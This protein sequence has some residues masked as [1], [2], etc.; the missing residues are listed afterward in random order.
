MGLKDLFSRK[1]DPSTE[2]LE[3]AGGQRN[4]PMTEINLP[5]R[6]KNDRFIPDKK[7]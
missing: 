5:P 6:D 3:N 2:G 4:K 1:A 7:T